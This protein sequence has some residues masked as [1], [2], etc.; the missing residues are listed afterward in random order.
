MT[1]YARGGL[2]VLALLIVSVLAAVPVLGPAGMRQGASDG[3]G[4]PRR[5]PGPRGVFVRVLSQAVDA[6]ILHHTAIWL[7]PHDPADVIG[8]DI[9]ATQFTPDATAA[10]AAWARRS[11]WA[12]SSVRPD[13]GVVSVTA[14][15]ARI[16][17]ALRVTIND[18][19]LPS[20][21]TFR[22]NDRP[23]WS[24]PRSRFSLSW[25]S[26]PTNGRRSRGRLSRQRRRHRP[27]AKAAT[28]SL[29]IF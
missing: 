15:T 22:A 29:L 9:G 11:G 7:G 26:P 4:A 17:K 12:V 6:P 10:I 24:P 14:P 20:G 21:Y 28:T 8:L 1:Q 2:A 3:E 18:Y 5:T 23:P 13:N 19:R 27:G 16:E 25:D